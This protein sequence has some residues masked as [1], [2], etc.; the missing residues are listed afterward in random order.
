MFSRLIANN[1]KVNVFDFMLVAVAALTAVYSGG[2]A[3]IVNIVSILGVVGV[4]LGITMSYL[5]RR[6]LEGSKLLTLDWIP[7]T[8]VMVC[9]VVFVREL[10]SAFP[11]ETF[12]R[13][14]MPSS[15]L[16][17]ML[18]LGSFFVW[19]DRTLL[20]HAIPALAMFGFVAC[21]DTFR[22]VIFFFF[23]YLICFATL[24]A[25]AHARDM[26]QRA[27]RSGF[28]ANDPASIEQPE[29]Q[30]VQLREGPWRW[31]A[32]PEWALWSAL[33]IVLLSLLGAPVIR[34]TVKPIAGV[35][36]L[37]NPVSARAF[38]NATTSGSN[39]TQTAQKV[40]NGPISLTDTPAFD[41]SSTDGQTQ[42]DSS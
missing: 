27:I 31:A 42:S 4:L 11:E 24:F 39:M 38:A 7:Y 1:G 16:F 14:L 6:L 26:Q 29:R 28:F 19:S 2:Q 23:I 21:Y 22:P 9:C 35:I 5:F 41:V 3:V 40:G 37:V 17:W 30:I 20:F 32:G 36:R 8:V 18:T 15:W 10:N 13:E 12:P 33:G 34:F 25:R